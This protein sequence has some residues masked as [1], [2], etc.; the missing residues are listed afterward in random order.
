MDPENNL[1]DEFSM[2]SLKKMLICHLPD[3]Y[4]NNYNSIEDTH[5][6]RYDEISK[7]FSKIFGT[8]VHYFLRVPGIINIMG[9]PLKSYGFDPLCITIDQDIVF[10]F[11]LTNKKDIVVHNSQ[12][13]LYPPLIFPADISQKFDEENNY[14]NL[15]LSGLKAALQDT[16]VS[17]PKGISIF[18]SSNL[19]IKAGLMSSSA[20]MF[21]MFCVIS[22]ANNLNKRIFQEEI[23]ENLMKFEKIH[24]PQMQYKYHISS[25][26]FNKKGT[27]Y[28]QKKSYE[29]PKKYNF[30]I[31]NSLTPTPTLFVSGNRQYKRL[32]ECRIGLAMMM[33]KMEM[34]DFSQ[35]KNLNEFQNILGYSNE[36]MIILLNDSIEK[37][38]YKVEE[39]EMMF[40]VP[41]AKLIADVPYV[42]NVL[43]TN[44]EFHPYEYFF[45]KN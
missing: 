6:P 18:I 7:R 10:A 25:L 24:F 38:N 14:L 19:P 20:L 29:L 37:K 39:I 16:L 28:Y 4:P 11:A 43:Q 33:K 35:V 22:F 5:I 21:G 17:S 32:V 36:E 15:L 41:I 8:E 34:K 13:A 44:K 2:Q 23:H 26:L 3:I 40:E 42:N 9:D 30:I 1:K 27:T 45:K 12:N 31:A